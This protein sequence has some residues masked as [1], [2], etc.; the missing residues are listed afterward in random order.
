MF[1]IEHYL[2]DTGHDPFADWYHGLKDHKARQA[3]D[4]RLNRLALGN[5]GDCRFC[6]HGVWELRINLG[7]G[8]RVYY[9][10]A[11][12]TLVLLLCGGDKRTQQT[13][14]TRACTYWQ[15][16]QSKQDDDDENT[17]T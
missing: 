9:A 8:Y 11:G 10:Q 13:D 5:F 16:F 15:C 12:Q 3:V 1:E 4:R 6:S 17:I 2:T 7:P 14:I